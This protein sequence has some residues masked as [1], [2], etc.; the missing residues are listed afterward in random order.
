MAFLPHYEM[1]SCTKGYSVYNYLTFHRL[2]AVVKKRTFYGQ[3]DC[4]GGRA[5]PS[6]LIVSKCENLDPFLAVKDSSISDIFGLSVGLS[7][8]TNNQSL[9]S[10]KE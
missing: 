4:K 3:A 6:A 1:L 7:E 10:I 8:Q 9:G 5:P 2:R